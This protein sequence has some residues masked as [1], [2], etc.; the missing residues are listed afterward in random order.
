MYDEVTYTG[1]KVETTQILWPSH[2][3][4]DTEDAALYRDLYVPST[5]DNVIH[6]NKGT[7]PDID[8]YSAFS[9]NNR[10]KKTELD[11]KLRERNV[12]HVFIAGLATD[13]CVGGTALDAF[14]LN[15]TTYL[16][17][18][19]SGVIAFDVAK[20]KLD[21]LK[22]Q[23]I[24]II[25]ANQVKA[26]SD[27]IT[28]QYGF[29]KFDENKLDATTRLSQYIRLSLNTNAETVVKFMQQGWGLTKPDLIISIV[30]GTTS[31]NMLPCLRKI[32][33]SDLVAVAIT[34]NAWLITAGTN[35][36]VV[37]EVGEALNKYRYKKRKNGID[38]PCIGI[39]S[40]GYT[41][42]NEQI[43]Y[44]PTT[45]FTHSDTTKRTYSFRK[46]HLNQISNS[47]IDDQYF[48]RNYSIT[49]KQKTRCDL[50]P[51]HTHFLL[52]DDGQPNADTVLPLR[53]EIEKY[54]RYINIETTTEEIIESLIPI[55]MILVEGDSSS[56]RT[57]CQ[58]LNS[59]T[60]VVVIKESGR[61]ADLI[62]ELYACYTDDENSNTTSYSTQLVRDNS[63]EI[64]INMIAQTTITGL[65]EVKYE[66]CRVL[67]ERK[68][69]VTIFMFNSK[70]HH[71]NLEDAI[72]ESLF[73]AAKFSDD[74]NEEHR[75]R[76]E[77]KLAIAWHKFNYAQKY[78]LTDTT[79][80]K[81][82]EDD[83]CR[84]LVDALYRGH[85]DFVELI[86][87]YGTSLEKLTNGD[88]KQLYAIRLV[89]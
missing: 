56:I 5:S 86:I 73:N 43:D 6:I 40:W 72:L 66:L 44:Q 50:E 31:F 26:L 22:Q 77:L 41:A 81:W 88:L 64:E 14:D 46:H 8:S 27:E 79:I 20:A 12:T 1:P 51:N 89:Y 3:I 34:T 11:R 7:D 47:D 76:V 59:N 39:T 13:Y 62:A 38:I 45:S 19:A 37:K 52:F 42:G 35:A 2:C 55:V 15:Y 21:H 33:Q 49:E 16:I 78:L 23:G 18:D 80:S 60:P 70:R 63:K 61:A 68:Q 67:N 58:A 69:L 84:A 29:I 83:L 10:I 57:I 87:E 82:K 71:R 30:G 9:D 24:E 48:I 4:Q 32:F 75:R 25:Q 17:E 36:G 54:S 53:A 65:D 28:K 74:F 85:V